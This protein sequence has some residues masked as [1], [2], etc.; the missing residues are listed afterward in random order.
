VPQVRA[1]RRHQ[2]AATALAVSV[3]LLLTACTQ[4]AARSEKTS[5]S[6]AAQ[7]S[8]ADSQ[9]AASSAQALASS[10]SAAALAAGVSGVTAAS[11]GAASSPPPV[12]SGIDPLTGLPPKSP[13]AETRPALAVKIDNVLGAWPQAGL[14]QADIVYDLPV[15]GGLTRLLAIF[16]SQDVGVFGPIRSARPVDA[17]ILHLLGHAYFAFSGGTS[18]DLGPINDH[19]NATPMWWDVTPSLFVIRHDHAVPHQVFGTTAM[20]Y[21]GGEARSASTTPPPPMFSYQVEVPTNAVPATTVTAQYSAATAGWTWNG[22]Q[23]LRNQ[24][25]HADL[26]IDGSQVTATNVVVMSVGVK[27]TSAH[28]SHGTVVPLPVVIGSGQVWV[29]RNG[30]V[31]HGT[32]I[33]PNENSPMKLVTTTG[34]VIPLM[35]GRTWVEVLPNSSLPKIS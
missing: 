28:D 11:P 25:G 16:H 34:Q 1:R 14:N 12:L 3:G 23:Y 18:S 13:S 26:L 9:A 22:T 33:R 15:E 7:V 6:S 30:V 27:N 2:A 35:P 21:A 20:L 31:V 19:S 4:A 17:D 29:F 5:A 8:P 10:A 32:W 24:S